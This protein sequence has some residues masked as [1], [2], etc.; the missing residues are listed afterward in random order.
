MLALCRFGLL[1]LTEKKI[2][3]PLLGFFRDKNKQME[4]VIHSMGPSV[5]T[6]Q[7]TNGPIKWV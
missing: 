4:H 7:G 3:F 1:Y 6:Q 2:L 5:M